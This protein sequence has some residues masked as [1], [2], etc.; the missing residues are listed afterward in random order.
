M[1]ASPVTPRLQHFVDDEML[2]APLLFDQIIDGSQ[3]RVRKGL[4]ILGPLQ[5]AVAVDVLQAL[6]AHRQHLADAFLRS[7]REQ[8]QEDLA[9]HHPRRSVAPSTPR[10]LALVD[11]DTVALD[12]ELSHAIE[13]IKSH[14]EHE[15]R[16]LQTYTS[17]LVG[18]MDVTRDHNPFRAETYARALGAAVQALPLSPA[19]Q[20]ALMHPAGLALAPLLRMAYASASSRL[21]AQGVE[22]AAYR[23]VILPSGVRSAGRF[24]ETTFSPDLHRMRD[25]MSAPLDELPPSAAGD[26]HAHGTAPRR[27]VEPREHWSDIAGSAANRADRQ[28][29][30]LVS[31]LFD[32]MLAD[33]RVPADAGLVI[34]RLHNPAL[35][36][37]LRDASL[38]DQDKHPLWRF[39]N[40]LVFE[41]QMTPD[42]HDPDRM[43]L[44][45]LAH[46][47]AEQLAAEP[48]QDAN[49]YRWACDRLESFLQ[50]RFLRRLSAA[51]SH[52]G[53]LQKLEDKLADGQTG[54]T[55]LHGML[56]VSQL[57][58]VPAELMEAGAPLPGSRADAEAWLDGLMP[59]DWVRL[60]LQGRWVHAALLWPG[61]RREVWLFGDGGSDAT[62][63]VRCG[64]LLMMHGTRLAKRLKQRSIV[65]SAAM[66]VHQ[67]MVAAQGA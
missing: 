45:K 6:Q 22:P 38:L 2:R 29:V 30:E 32:A 58:T 3:A 31:R 12:V 59:G 7:L 55:T 37:T 43:Q 41:A 14:C 34:A 15:L 66:R 48:E 51:S 23:T 27:A 35:R 54:L 60:F 1:A 9:W 26:R 42:S 33:D 5:R 56:D 39:I 44:L 57:D 24:G 65:S 67:Q 4:P 17:A 53:A 62:W 46:S 11:E 40:R 63:A 18:D 52:I 16:D 21:E 8:V 47:T 28:A 25:S 64:A 50:K 61:E 13:L 10:A 19:H 20:V 49:L 36:M